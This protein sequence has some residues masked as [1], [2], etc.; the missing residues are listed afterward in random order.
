[1]RPE[2]QAVEQGLVSLWAT[3]FLQRRIP[4]SEAANNV[5]LDLILQQEVKHSSQNNDLTTDYLA[6]NFLNTEHPVVEWL[7]KCLNHG[8]SEYLQLCKIDYSVDWT[9]QAWA[10]INRRGD[11]HNVHNHPHSYLSGTYYIAMPTSASREHLSRADL[12]P[13]AISFY[14]PRAQANMLAIKG[15]AQVDPEYR[16]LPEPGM[17]LLWPSFV[18]HMVHPNLSDELRVSVSFNVILKWRNEY[19]PS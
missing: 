19:V 18:H 2:Q 6:Q 3:H 14:D 8:V 16:V 7:Q 15:D 10:N 9:L 12:N 11:Y 5:L 1:M 17:L 13:G 4:N